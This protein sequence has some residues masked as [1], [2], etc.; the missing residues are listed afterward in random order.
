MPGLGAGGPGGSKSG[1]RVRPGGGFNPGLGSPDQHQDEAAMKAAVKQKQLQQQQSSTQAGSGKAGTNPLLQKTAD[2]QQQGPDFQSGKPREVGSLKD[3]L[4][5]RP[6]KDVKKGLT[7]LVSLEALFNVNADDTPEEK[8]KKQKLH[9]RYQKLNQEQQQV[10]KKKYQEKLQRQKHEREEEAKK[11]QA[12]E[13]KKQQQQAVA[14][15]SSPKKGPAGP[16]AGQ[17]KKKQAAQRLQQ[18]RQGLGK[19]GQ[20]N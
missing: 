15:P 4:I 7:S 8:V 12:A 18:N 9:Q 10:A 6:L 20:K 3:E 1:A 17:K 14:P 5:K 16:T 19:V 13:V 2:K 11:K